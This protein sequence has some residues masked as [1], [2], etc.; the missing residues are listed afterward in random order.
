MTHHQNRPLEEV[1]FGLWLVLAAVSINRICSAPF[2][3]DIRFDPFPLYDIMYEGENVGISLGSFIYIIAIH[4]A[5]L[6]L[7]IREIRK[8][9]ETSILFYRFFAIE[10]V[11]LIDFFIIYEHAWFYIGNYGVEFTDIKILLYSYFILTWKK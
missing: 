4:C 6:I 2:I 10:C 7:W 11:S 3:P 9:D 1:K 8:K 5:W